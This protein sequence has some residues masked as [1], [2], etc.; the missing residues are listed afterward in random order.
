M[1]IF[2]SNL[3]RDKN[4]KYSIGVYEWVKKE[5]VSNWLMLCKKLLMVLILIMLICF[6]F[7]CLISNMLK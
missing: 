4:G 2:E 6:G 1:V 5:V 3:N 7:S